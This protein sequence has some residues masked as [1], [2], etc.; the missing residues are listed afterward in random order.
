M[1]DRQRRRR[2]I[3]LALVVLVT[4]GLVAGLTA[5]GA[6]RT[7][8]FA[9]YDARH[10]IRG[11]RSAPEDIVVV[12]LDG[13]SLREIGLRTPYPRSIHA[14]L[15]ERLTAGGA[16]AVAY[17]FQFH[18]TTVESEDER[19]LEAI[20]RTPRLVLATHDVRGAPLRIPAGEDPGA[21]GA[22][23]GNVGLITDSDGTIRRAPYTGQQAPSFAPQLVRA[24]GHEVGPEEFPALIDYRGPPRT[25]RTFPFAGVLDG[26]VPAET[27]RDRIVVVG[28]TDPIEKDTFQTPTSDKFMP[29]AEI[30]ANAIATILAGFPL[31]R[32]PR[33]LDV[34]LVAVMAALVPLVTVGRSLKEGIAA[35]VVALAGFLVGAQLAFG[36]GHVL[37]VMPPLLALVLSAAGAGLVE[38]ATV[39]RERVRLRR[40]FSRFVP[41]QVVD[42]V[43]DR[44]GDDF[45][46]MGQTMDATVMFCDLRGFTAF[47]ESQPA[48]T[49]IEALNRYLGEMSEAV[50]DH[51]GT[52]VAFLGDGMMAVFGAPLEQPDH[53]DRAL[54]AAREMLDVRL[55]RFNAWVRERGAGDDFRLGIGVNS[56][57]VS[58][59]TVGSEKRLEYAAVGDTTN[60]AARLQAHTKETP[61][62]LLVS[63]ATR[64]RMAGA[65]DG[66]A[67]VGEVTLRGRSA[68]IRLWTLA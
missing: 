27:F 17:D 66:L 64:E 13:A 15:L 1:T 18:G 37:A 61:H 2:R 35:A 14:R 54:A 53:A 3:R 40:A 23:V 62:A 60:V 19:L 59:G 30:H 28:A 12:G 65:G 39:T 56:G 43:M 58:S 26:D 31:Q 20:A 33:W 48:S 11:D 57:P 21:L 34:L 25:F 24:L 29:G 52:V 51:G 63:D 67:P 45:A 36:A 42:D 9:S 10:G 32:A 5:L 22:R 38:Y 68:P 47:S 41:E 4:G 44:A 49:V 50:L 16:R 46:L 6:L 8:E 7:L 55:A